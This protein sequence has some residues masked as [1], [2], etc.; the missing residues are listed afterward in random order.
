MQSTPTAFQT[1]FTKFFFP[2][3]KCEITGQSIKPS[4]GEKVSKTWGRL[5]WEFLRGLSVDSPFCWA[6]EITTFSPISSQSVTKL[7]RVT[8]IFSTAYFPIIN[9]PEPL[10]KWE[11][12][13]SLL[14]HPLA[15]PRKDTSERQSKSLR[16]ENTFNIPEVTRNIKA[17]N[18]PDFSRRLGASSTSIHSR[19]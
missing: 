12:R 10:K 4:P 18:D 3:N 17:F 14:S 1:L 13:P 6:C 16:V 19:S 7:S 15:I 9:P 2:T 5:P 11:L 8:R